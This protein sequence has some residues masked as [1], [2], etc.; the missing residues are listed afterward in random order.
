M[1]S[2]SQREVATL[3]SESYS[4][5]VVDKWRE[6]RA[7]FDRDHSMPNPYKETEDRMFSSAFI[8]PSLIR[9]LGLTIAK[10]QMEL[11]VEAKTIS[12]ENPLAVGGAQ[13]SSISPSTFFQKAIDLEERL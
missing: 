10:L 6:M 8:H 3:I 7:E 11:L 9:F 2:K 4:A 5:D 12:N 13:S 1:W